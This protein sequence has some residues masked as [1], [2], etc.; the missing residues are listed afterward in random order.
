MNF[1]IFDLALLALFVLSISFFLYR[2]RKNLKREGLLFLYKT[3]WGIKLIERVGNKY[4]KT[5]KVLSYISIGLGFLLMFAMIYVFGRIV[6]IYVFEPAIVQEIKIPPITPLIPYLP[7]IFGLNLPPFY[8][9]YWIVIIAVVAIT[10]E[11]AHGIFAAFNKVRIKKTGFGFFPFFLPIFLAAFVEPDEEEMSKKSVFGQMAIL[12]AGTF[13]NLITAIIFFFVLLGFFSASYAPAGV[14]FD[15]YSYSAVTLSSISSIG[16]VPLQNPSYE[17]ISQIVNQSDAELISVEAENNSYFLTKDFL[18]RQQNIQDYILLYDD[19]PALKA[20]ISGAITELNGVKIDSREKLV[21]ELQKYPPGEIVSIKSKTNEGEN[22]YEVRLGK[23][24]EN[25]NMPWLGIGFL[26][27][28][29]GFMSGLSDLLYLIRKPNVY[30]EEKFEAASFIYNLLWWLLLIS[31][32][33]ALMNML[34]MGIFDGGKFFYLT[35]F[36]ITKSKQKAQT[37]FKF[38]TYLFL[39]L[40]LVIMVFW[41]LSFR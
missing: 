8:F 21:Q 11:L 15:L 39:F 23:H 27:Q 37:A 17:Q 10:H 33:V 13:A 12:S 16:G 6:W 36:A 19:S 29:E 41:A 38:M 25:E 32:S 30:Y 40:V 26:N 14:T 24:P 7:Q 31:F 18:G 1:V 5:L 34:P 35:I 28:G 3:G 4:K 20:G 2:K 22:Q 9:T